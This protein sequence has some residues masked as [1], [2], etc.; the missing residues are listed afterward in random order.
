MLIRSLRCSFLMALCTVLTF[1][2]STPNIRAACSLNSAP[3][4]LT[5]PCAIACSSSRS[6]ALNAFHCMGILLFSCICPSRTCAAAS[7]LSAGLMIM[8]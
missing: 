3:Y 2:L 1:T 6:M 4:G 7:R 8:S 5:S